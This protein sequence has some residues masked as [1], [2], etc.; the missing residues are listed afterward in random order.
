MVLDFSQGKIIVTA[1]EVQVRLRASNLVLQAMAEDIQL[2]R[3]GR[4]LLADGG[5]VRWSLS[6]DDEAQLEQIREQL[7]L[8]YE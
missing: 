3:Q 4:L 8:D 7:G 2:K 6:L 5:A 1:F